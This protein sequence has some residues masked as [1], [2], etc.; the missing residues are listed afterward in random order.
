MKPIWITSIIV[1]ICLASCQ[2]I[3]GELISERYLDAVAMIESS[4]NIH[5]IGD[6]GKARGMF[7][8]HEAAWSDAKQRNPL[9]VDY[10]IGATNATAS[11][12]AAKTYLTI[13]AERFEKRVK[14][15]PTHGELYACYNMGFGS[16]AKVGFD[17]NRA[18]VTTRKAV[19]R[20]EWML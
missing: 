14:R 13:L 6:N 19:K 17:L 9:V 3:K 12:L 5:A 20:I 1:I 7:Q 2:K 18:P 8:L 11:R 4:G 10:C 16:F 15:K